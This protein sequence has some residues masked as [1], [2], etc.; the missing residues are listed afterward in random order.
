[1]DNFYETIDS[2]NYELKLWETRTDPDFLSKMRT[3]SIP[4]N[5]SRSEILDEDFTTGAAIRL[6]AEAA[7]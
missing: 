5:T 2:K 3:G 1:M 7:L 6:L 4:I